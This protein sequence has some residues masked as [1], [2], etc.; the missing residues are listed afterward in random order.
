MNTVVTISGVRILNQRETN[1][2]LTKELHIDFIL[3]GVYF[4]NKEKEKVIRKIG[5]IST[6][7]K[8]MANLITQFFRL[9]A[10]VIFCKS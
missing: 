2:S 4:F 10:I 8:L 3:N 5:Q 6:L 7:R 1:Q 9:N